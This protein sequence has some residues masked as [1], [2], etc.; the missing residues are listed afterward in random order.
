MGRG[1]TRRVLVGLKEAGCFELQACRRATTASGDV[2]VGGGAAAKL[3][4]LGHVRQ[5]A[6]PHIVRDEDGCERQPHV[7]KQHL[8]LLRNA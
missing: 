6:A 8:G 4:G 7:G 2:L 1:R 5:E 3:L